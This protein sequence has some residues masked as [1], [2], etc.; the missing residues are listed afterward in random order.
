M[1]VMEPIA[2]LCRTS[3]LCP[4]SAHQD[5]MLVDRPPTR[6]RAS[7][8]AEVD[9]FYAPIIN[10]DEYDMRGF[11]EEER[12]YFAR[13]PRSGIWVRLEDL[14]YETRNKLGRQR[15]PRCATFSC[16]AKMRLPAAHALSR[17]TDRYTQAPKKPD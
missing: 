5:L 4:R 13:S 6:S 3:R 8:T 9:Y 14:P 16:Y 7:N 12:E 10:Y 11:Y 17:K 2:D 15:P 1:F